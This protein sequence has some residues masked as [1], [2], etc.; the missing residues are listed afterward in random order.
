MKEKPRAAVEASQ[1]HHSPPSIPSGDFRFGYQFDE[2]T[3]R[4]ISLK[5]FFS[6]KN[7]S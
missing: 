4:V 5:Q 7:K 3:Q 2:R 1:N 6:G